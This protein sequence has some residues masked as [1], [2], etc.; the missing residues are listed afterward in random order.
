MRANLRANGEEHVQF[1][2]LANT[3]RHH[4]RRGAA[5]FEGLLRNC[6]PIAPH[7]PVRDVLRFDAR[8]APRAAAQC[9]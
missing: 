5:A 7:A 1:I 6:N 2:E 4:G 3:G 8:A 9:A